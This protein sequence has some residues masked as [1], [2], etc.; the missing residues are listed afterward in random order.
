VRPSS[1]APQLFTVA[2]IGTAGEKH[3]AR[4]EKR[5]TTYGASGHGTV[6]DRASR[7]IRAAFA[8]Q[9]PRLARNTPH[10]SRVATL[11]AALLNLRHVNA[12]A[13]LLSLSLSLSDKEL[14]TAR[15]EK[16]PVAA[17]M[18]RAAISLALAPYR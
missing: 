17:P 7:G 2:H 6:A 18:F 13:V 16:L 5:P 1:A 3:H 11:A 12:V 8:M 15:G 4:T 14:A 10:S 9:I